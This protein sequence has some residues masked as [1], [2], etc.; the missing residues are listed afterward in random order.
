ME[1]IFEICNDGMDYI[2]ELADCRMFLTDPNSF[3]N[4]PDYSSREYLPPLYPKYLELIDDFPIYSSSEIKEVDMVSV[5][6]N[7]ET[8]ISS[9]K[10]KV[11]SETE[12]TGFFPIIEGNLPI[13]H[14]RKYLKE[15]FRELILGIIRKNSFSIT[16]PTRLS[17]SSG[18]RSLKQEPDFIIK[19][20]KEK[21]FTLERMPY[22]SH[23]WIGGNGQD[24]SLDFTSSKK[25]KLRIK[26]K[27][28]KVMEEYFYVT[29]SF[30][31]GNNKGMKFTQITQVNDSSIIFHPIRSRATVSLEHQ[32]SEVRGWRNLDEIKLPTLAN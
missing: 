22:F 11:P 3:Q 2:E 31:L 28:G 24:L 7:K 29:V 26:P 1:D 16:E 6:D 8:K 12:D 20:G 19:N 21:I 25:V 27:T 5:T 15:N 17:L 30:I 18:T 4:F 10:K 9:R 14:A 23:Y 13:S 32:R